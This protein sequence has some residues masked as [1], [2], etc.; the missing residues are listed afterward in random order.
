[1][2]KN[3]NLHKAK[4]A[5]ND[6]FYTRIEDVAEE[7]RHY[8]K[9]FAGKVVLCNCDDPTWSAFWRYFHLNFAELGLKKLI[10]THYDRTEPTY[11]ME[12]EGGNDNDVEVGVKTPLEG[13]GDFRNKECIELV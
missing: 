10:S 7:L 2:A 5:K 6:E 4:D 1:M 9:H 13:N 8:K 11:K 3:D 12:Y